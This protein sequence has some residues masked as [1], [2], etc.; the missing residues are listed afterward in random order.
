MKVPF[1][2]KRATRSLTCFNIGGEATQ[3]SGTLHAMEY[4]AE[5]EQVLRP[6]LLGRPKKPSGSRAQNLLILASRVELKVSRRPDT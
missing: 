2:S 5:R 4:M 6:L 1:R 3:W